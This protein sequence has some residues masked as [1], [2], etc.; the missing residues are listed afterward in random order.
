[1]WV[2]LPLGTL[3]PSVWEAFFIKPKQTPPVFMFSIKI[4]NE[5]EHQLRIHAK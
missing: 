5:H 1:M 2:R 4:N 3:K